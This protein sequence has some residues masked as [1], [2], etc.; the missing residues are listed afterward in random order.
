MTYSHNDPAYFASVARRARLLQTAVGDN[1]DDVPIGLINRMMDLTKQ[2]D[3]L[4]RHLSNGGYKRNTGMTPAFTLA[5]FF[6]E[7]PVL[8]R[9]RYS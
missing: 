8:R 7:A 4:G 6:I 5:E 1:I 9:I 2:A 3:E